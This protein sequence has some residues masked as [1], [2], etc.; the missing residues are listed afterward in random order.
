MYLA[1][2]SVRRVED[3][4][5]LLMGITQTQRY[6]CRLLDSGSP[7]DSI[8]WGVLGVKRLSGRPPCSQLWGSRLF[9]VLRERL[10]PGLPSKWP[11]PSIPITVANPQVHRR[12][13]QADLKLIH[14]HLSLLW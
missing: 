5:L 6:R 11:Q 10:S 7:Q 13:G 8:S 1:G 14:S 4:T 2:I 3:I 9:R 12:Q